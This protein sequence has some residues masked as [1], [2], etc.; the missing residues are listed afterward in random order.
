M[1]SLINLY[2]VM[3]GEGGV[4]DSRCLKVDRDCHSPNPDSIVAPQRYSPSKNSE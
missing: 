3:G 2:I 1:L 4:L